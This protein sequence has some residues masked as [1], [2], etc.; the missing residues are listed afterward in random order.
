MPDMGTAD[1]RGEKVL[2]VSRDALSICHRAKEMAHDDEPSLAQWNTPPRCGAGAEDER[3]SFPV[4]LPR[5]LSP[6]AMLQTLSR[7]FDSLR[8]APPGSVLPLPH[9][10]LHFDDG[11]HARCQL[12]G[13]ITVLAP[14]GAWY[15][16]A[17]VVSLHGGPV[18]DARTGPSCPPAPNPVEGACGRDGRNQPWSVGGLGWI[19]RDAGILNASRFNLL[20]LD[21]APWAPKDQKG[22]EAQT[23][24]EIGQ[25]IGKNTRKKRPQLDV[26]VVGKP[27]SGRQ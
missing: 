10:S 26:D 11:R 14:Y 23:R 16:A 9:R 17:A 20:P 22:V 5:H 1:Q 2:E 19:V 3:T 4:S 12:L 18:R 8:H 24:K 13:R 25:P 6:T 27:E 7:A 15:G 21:F